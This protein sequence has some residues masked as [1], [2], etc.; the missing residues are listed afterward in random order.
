MSGRAPSTPR[1]EC[2]SSGGSPAFSGGAF[3]ALRVMQAPAEHLKAAAQTEDHPAAAAVRGDVDVESGPTV[4][5]V[6]PVA[7]ATPEAE[8]GV[9]S[10]V[11][12]SGEVD[13]AND[14]VQVAAGAEGVIG[15]ATQPAIGR[16]PFE[17]VT[18][19][20]GKPG[21]EVTAASNV[22]I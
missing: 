18:V 20:D 12:K 2:R 17:K 7:V 6:D 19:P 14:V 13:A 3:H 1:R 10:A 15:S 8:S 21:L 11:T 22:T 4:T 16:P 9:K 5:V